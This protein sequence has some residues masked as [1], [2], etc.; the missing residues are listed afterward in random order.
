MP[1]ATPP[2]D[3]ADGE[4]GIDQSAVVVDGGVAIERDFSCFGIDL[5]FGDVATVGEGDDVEQ[6]PDIGVE[7]G[8]AGDGQQVD[9]GV[10]R[11]CSGRRRR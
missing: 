1:W 5:D 6:V 8:V 7:A 11:R 4:Q 10:R 3:L 2:L 9:G